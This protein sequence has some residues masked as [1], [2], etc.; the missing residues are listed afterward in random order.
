[1]CAVRVLV[2]EDDKVVVTQEAAHVLRRV[3]DAKLQAQNLVDGRELRVFQKV[4]E[5]FGVNLGRAHVADDPA[6]GDHTI[7][8][9]PHNFHTRDS[10][11]LGRIALGSQQI[12]GRSVELAG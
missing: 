5:H 10:Q 2:T 4:L 3:R 11:I 1:M 6:Q 8:V 7:A 12:A 9:T